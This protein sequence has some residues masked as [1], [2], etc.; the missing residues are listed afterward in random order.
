MRRLNVFSPV[1]FR[2]FGLFNLKSEKKLA[3]FG[4]PKGVRRERGE[5]TKQ[6]VLNLLQ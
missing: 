1:A 2:L 5:F 4:F 6:L 3:V